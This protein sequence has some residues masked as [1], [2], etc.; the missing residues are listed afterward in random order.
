AR[1]LVS[2]R[3][4]DRGWIDRAEPR[5]GERDREHEREYR[6]AGNDTRIAQ[7]TPAHMGLR[8]WRC[9]T[10]DFAQIGSDAHRRG[11]LTPAPL[12]QER[13]SLWCP[14]TGGVIVVPLPPG[15][16]DARKRGG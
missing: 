14:P 10:V 6:R 12:P 2:N 1:Q 3:G 15:E 9:G 4:I 16:A 7:Q 11:T 5:R 13:G 8:R